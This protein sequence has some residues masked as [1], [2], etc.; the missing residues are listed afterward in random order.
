MVSGCPR[1]AI[2]GS[3]SCAP[4]SASLRISGTGLI[5][6]FSG[7]KPETIA[8]AAHGDRK[9]ALRDRLGGG[10]T[11]VGRQGIAAG[12]RFPADGGFGI[13]NGAGVVI[14]RTEGEKVRSRDG[15]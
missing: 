2:A 14:H 1:P 15:R 11:H 8:S 12:E 7:M 6:L 5:S 4:A 10:G 3:A 9:R 13:C